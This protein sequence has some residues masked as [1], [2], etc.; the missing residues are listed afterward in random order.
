MLNQNINLNVYDINKL[1][2]IGH[3]F[4]IGFYHLSV[5]IGEIEYQISH[6][7]P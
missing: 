3:F 6:S 1:N 7:K 2:G 5:T 4:G